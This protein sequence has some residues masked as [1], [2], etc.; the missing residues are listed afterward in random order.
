MSG[1]PFTDDGDN[2]WR[3]HEAVL[4]ETYLRL[5]CVWMQRLPTRCK[6]ISKG[7]TVSC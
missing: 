3:A 1:L 7:G 5:V 6:N 2:G 4:F